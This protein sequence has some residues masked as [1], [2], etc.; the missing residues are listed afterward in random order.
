MV[1][2]QPIGMIYEVMER[3]LRAP[4]PDLAHVHDSALKINGFARAALTSCLDVVTW[5]APDEGTRTQVV[6]GVR[7]CV[8]LLATSLSFRGFAIRN[9]VSGVEGD[10]YRAGIRCVLT[11]ALVH[12]TD[13]NPPPADVVLSASAEPGGLRLELELRATVGNHCFAS[14]ADYRT[15]VSNFR[16]FIPSIP[17]TKH[18]KGKK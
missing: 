8:G 16:K 11:A 17:T 4:Q 14:E 3:R 6:E 7:E 1:N 13:A 15:I 18:P 12:A 5:L 10:V 2:L 9:E